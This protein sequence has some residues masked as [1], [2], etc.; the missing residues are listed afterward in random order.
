MTGKIDDPLIEIAKRCIA[1]PT[2]YDPCGRLFGIS[3]RALKSMYLKHGLPGHRDTRGIV[4]FIPFEVAAWLCRF[5][6][7]AYGA[8]KRY[9]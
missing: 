9:A 2:V 6:K 3:R 7:E 4:R 1:R 5:D 8:Q